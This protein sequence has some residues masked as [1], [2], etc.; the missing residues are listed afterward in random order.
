MEQVILPGTYQT[1]DQRHA[2]S[3]GEPE[4]QCDEKSVQKKRLSGQEDKAPMAR[5][6]ETAKP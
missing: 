1:V 6:E 2:G 4:S 5:R 3:H